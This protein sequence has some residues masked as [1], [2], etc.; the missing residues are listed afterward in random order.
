MLDAEMKS[1]IAE[2]KNNKAVR[3]DGIPAE[4]WKNHGDGAMK[5]LIDLCKDISMDMEQ[6]V[7]SLLHHQGFAR[8][9]LVFHQLELPCCFSFQLLLT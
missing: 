8:I 6:S 1:A 5:E 9:L 4:F 7:L 2:M 3:V